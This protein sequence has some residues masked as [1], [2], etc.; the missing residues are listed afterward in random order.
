MSS[1]SLIQTSY[2]NDFGAASHLRA[3]AKPSAAGGP[4][5]GGHG[6]PIGRHRHHA[7]QLRL[8]P[9]HRGLPGLHTMVPPPLP[10]H[11]QVPEGGGQ[12]QPRAFLKYLFHIRTAD[13]I[14]LRVKVDADF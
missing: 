14:V 8:H 2:S 1:S 11:A 3:G 7:A 9:A 12:D 10:S 4:P 6:P 5:R 13:P